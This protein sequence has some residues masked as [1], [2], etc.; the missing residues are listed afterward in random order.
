MN[1]SSARQ[2]SYQEIQQR[3]ESINLDKAALYIAQE[4]YPDLDP[5]E[6]LNA[7]VSRAFK[8]QGRL[9]S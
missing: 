9:P 6:Y 1:F 5:K 4:E 2:Y 8:L 3:D 7:I